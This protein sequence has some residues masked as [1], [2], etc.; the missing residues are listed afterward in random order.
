MKKPVAFCT[1][2]SD[3]YYHSYGVDKLVKSAK[4]F[5]PGIPF[6]VFGTEDVEKTGIPY[7]IV[8]PF[9][10]H[11]LIDDYEMVVRFDA[12]S[13]LTGPI[14]EI[15]N[16]EGYELICV[17]NNNDY[18]RAGKDDP[19]AQFNVSIHDYVNSGL[20]ATTSK[21]FIEEWMDINL[22]VG[23]MLPFKEQ[24]TLNGIKRK[25]KTLI[26]D[27]KESEVYYGVSGL[28]GEE[29]HWDS[30]RHINTIDGI[31]YLNG[32]KVKVLHHAGGF[33]ENKLGFYMFNDQTR[34]RLIEI[35]S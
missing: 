11:K 35:T 21:A 3:P 30:W 26:V 10:M 7:Q 31:L 22:S 28:F 19:I 32:K 8:Q 17:R 12:D 20:V 13:M 9:I 5:H 18:D 34:K 29:G 6:Y 1:N 24:S 14:E 23:T 15:L 33:S 16:H 25:Y 27:P 4:Y 2:I